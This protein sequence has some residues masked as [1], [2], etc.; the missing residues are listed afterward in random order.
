M[1]QVSH[2][3]NPL[4]RIIPSIPKPGTPE[5]ELNRSSVFT[6]KRLFG[7]APT[8]FPSSTLPHTTLSH[9]PSVRHT[10]AEGTSSF[11]FLFFFPSKSSCCNFIECFI[12]TEIFSVGKLGLPDAC[13]GW[14]LLLRTLLNGRVKNVLPPP[15]SI[16]PSERVV[17]VVMQ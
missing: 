2:I 14:Q 7:G 1:G 8:Q 13:A 16:P 5:A 12:I 15:S 6:E 10:P 9:F 3:P 11:F 17:V 4:I